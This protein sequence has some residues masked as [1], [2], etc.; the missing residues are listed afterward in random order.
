MLGRQWRRML[1]ATLVAVAALGLH[2]GRAADRSHASPAGLIVFASDRAKLN[3]GEIYSLAPGTQARDVTHSLAGEHDLAVAPRGDLIAFWSNRS[4]FD[5]VYLAHADGSRVRL[6]PG[7]A[8]GQTRTHQGNGARLQFAAGGSLLIAVFSI[9]NATHD[10]AI[11]PRTAAV[12][13]LPPVRLRGRPVAGWH[14]DRVQPQRKRPRERVRRCGPRAFQSSRVAALLVQPRLADGLADIDDRP[15]VGRGGRRVRSHAR[16]RERPAAGVVAGRRAAGVLARHLAA[17]RRSA[18]RRQ[19][20]GDLPGLLRRR[21][22]VHPRRPPDP[23]GRPGGQI[24][25][26]PRRGRTRHPCRGR[27]KRRLVARRATRLSRDG[28][29]VPS[30]AGR[31]V[32]RA[33]DRHARPQSTRGRAIPVRRSRRSASCSGCRTG[34]ASCSSRSNTCNGDDLFAVPAGGGA[35]RQLTHDPRNLG[36]SGL[37]T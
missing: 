17:G 16:T 6:V 19:R 8:A 1:L 15:A 37:V 10:Y 25:A 5:R 14:A 7:I 27:G 31:H 35:T 21:G 36:R 30:P 23:H 13:P 33:R 29:V 3:N 11:D 12:R 9:G 20:S 18:Q 34:G 4:G 24:R 28:V 22:V 32:P 2:A 26:D